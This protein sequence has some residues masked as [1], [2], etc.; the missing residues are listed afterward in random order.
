MAM[1]HPQTTTLS[2]YTLVLLV[3]FMNRKAIIDKTPKRVHSGNDSKLASIIILFKQSRLIIVNYCS[4]LDVMFYL[5]LPL[6]RLGSALCVDHKEDIHSSGM[7]D[8]TCLRCRPVLHHNFLSFKY[9]RSDDISGYVII[10]N[11]S[12]IFIDKKLFRLMYFKICIILFFL[13]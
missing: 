13:F 12:K 4:P 11:F 1:P 5:A 10:Y 7:E 9:K 2:Y 8:T 6:A 3:S